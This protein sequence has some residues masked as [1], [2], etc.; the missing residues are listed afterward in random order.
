MKPV[1]VKE[2]NMKRSQEQRP[3]TAGPPETVAEIFFHLSD[4]AKRQ[5]LQKFRI[6]YEALNGPTDLTRNYTSMWPQPQQGWPFANHTQLW[7][8]GLPRFA[9]AYLRGKA[10]L[11]ARDGRLDD[12][13]DTLL[14]L[15][16]SGGMNPRRAHGR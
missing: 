12:I 5:E 2:D 9:Q 10:E 13:P 1:P 15:Y 4:S 6:E 3:E 16:A 11:V 7:F 8:D 14:R